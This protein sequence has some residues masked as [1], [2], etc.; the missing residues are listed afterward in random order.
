MQQGLPLTGAAKEIAG[1]TIIANLCNVAPKRLPA[2][3]LPLVFVRHSAAQV[4]A[5]I[6]LKPA[7]RIVLV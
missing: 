7:A 3:D 1:L 4:V 5:A 2:F 6:P